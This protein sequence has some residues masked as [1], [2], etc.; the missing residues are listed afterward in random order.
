MIAA[1]EAAAAL[2]VLAWYGSSLYVGGRLL[3]AGIRDGNPHARWIGTYLFFAMGM[4]SILYSIAMARTAVQDSA[5]SQFFIN[6]NDNVPLNHGV[7][8]FGYAVFGKVTGGVDVVKKIAAVKTAN[9]G[10]HQN[11]P[12]EPVVIKSAKRS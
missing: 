7:R 9:A 1:L 11:V 8:D 12:V 3:Y 2:G 6:V 5:T 10:A 4:A